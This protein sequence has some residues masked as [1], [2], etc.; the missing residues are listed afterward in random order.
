MLTL[1][2]PYP[3]SANR[4]W[5][6]RVI[7]PKG[8]TRAMAMTYVT[9][10]AQ[11]FKDTVGWLAKAA[12]VRAPMP[13][14]VAIDYILHPKLPQDWAGRARKDPA[15]WDDTVMCVDLDNAQKVLID[16]LKDIVIMDDKW[17][18][19]ITARRGLPLPEACL[20]VK[21]WQI[22]AVAAQGSLLEAA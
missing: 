15:G 18:R 12:G 11:A 14:R 13:G 17:V 19:E 9:K 16:A 10:E 7:T 22:P 3:V 21:V 4:Y 2:L 5:A 20:I 8:H 1:K 6:T